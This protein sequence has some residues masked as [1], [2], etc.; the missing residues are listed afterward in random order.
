MD[1]VWPVFVQILPTYC[2]I[3][4]LKHM[5]PDFVDVAIRSWMDL[6]SV[7]K[8]KTSAFSLDLCVRANMDA[9]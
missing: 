7:N 5:L 2:I 8:Y 6:S 1:E 3:E 4:S 9:V